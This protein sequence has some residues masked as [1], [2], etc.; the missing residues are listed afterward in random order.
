M[1]HRFLVNNPHRTTLI[2]EPD[3]NLRRAQEADERNRLTKARSSRSADQLRDLMENTIELKRLQ[4]TPDPPEA[5]ATIPILKLEDLEKKN[6]TISLSHMD[7]EGTPVLFHDI[8]TSG[9]AYLDVGFNIHTLPERYLPYV[10]LFGRALLEMGTERENFVTLTQ[11]I[12]RKTGG[13]TP[14]SFTSKTK[15]APQSAAWLFLRGKVMLRQ[16][17]ALIGILRDIIL[18]RPTGPQNR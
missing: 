14:H 9:I 4:E 2:L 18:G 5:L 3:P 1:I 16:T 11:R 7:R 8:F 15:D 6:K 10:P 17:E 13:I 12:S